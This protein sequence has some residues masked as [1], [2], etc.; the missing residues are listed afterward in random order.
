MV[1]QA[2]SENI[3]LAAITAVKK[4]APFKDFPIDIGKETLNVVIPLSFRI[5]N[6]RY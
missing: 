4:S 3:N 2:P 5:K 1:S 6:I